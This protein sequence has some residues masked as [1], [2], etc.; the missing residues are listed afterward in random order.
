MATRAALFRRGVWVGATA[1]VLAC[2]ASVLVFLSRRSGSDGRTAVGVMYGNSTRTI[3]ARAEYRGGPEGK[4]KLLFAVI[5]SKGEWGDVWGWSTD[6]LRR[7]VVIR[8]PDLRCRVPYKSGHVYWVRRDRKVV[9]VTKRVTRRDLR[10]VLGL[11]RQ[12]VL[13]EIDELKG[14]LG[15]MRDEDV[16][17]DDRDLP[18]ARD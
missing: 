3:D 11:D 7:E 1:I 16:T 14:I 8:G 5:V 9:D 2:C 10:R 4:G 6:Y 17:S 13:F 18:A 15:S 12:A